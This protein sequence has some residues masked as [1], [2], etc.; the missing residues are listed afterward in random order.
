MTPV[1][2]PMASVSIR[3]ATPEDAEAIT[4]IYMQSA[5]H[6][7]LLDPERN[8]VP[9]PAAICERYRTGAQ[10]PAGEEGVTLVA[11]K[12]GEVLG[13]LDA[14]LIPPFDPMFRPVTLCFITDVAV[15]TDRRREGIGEQLMTAVEQWGS[16]RGAGLVAL[17]YLNANTRAASFYDRLGYRPKSTVAVKA[18]AS[19][20][21]HVR[22]DRDRG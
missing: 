2:Q 11:E 20:Q 15:A 12:H 1:K 7:A 17:E 19:L 13:F 6:H 22:D 9:D 21:N 18:V 10:H 5:E 16:S 3:V 8:Q 14:R 4:R